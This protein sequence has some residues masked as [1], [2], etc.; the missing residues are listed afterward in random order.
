MLPV[1]GVVLGGS[2]LSLIN[3]SVSAY[4]T[5]KTA[6]KNIESGEITFEPYIAGAG[7]GMK[8]SF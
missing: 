6:E 1:A 3:S 2:I 5:V 8:C 4:R 7:F